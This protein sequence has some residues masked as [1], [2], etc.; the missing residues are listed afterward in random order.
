MND[1]ATQAWAQHCTAELIRHITESVAHLLPNDLHALATGLHVVLE[2]TSAGRAP[3][4]VSTFQLN[5]PDDF[6]TTSLSSLAYYILNDLQDEVATYLHR[7]WPL[8]EAGTALHPWAEESDGVIQLAFRG[9]GANADVAP[10]ELAP[11]PVP[12]KPEGTVIVG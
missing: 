5:A 1:A 3:R 12:P 7:A 6:E 10:I 4:A 9:D 8:N 11:F 2:K